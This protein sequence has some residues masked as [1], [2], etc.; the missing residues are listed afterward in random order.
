MKISEVILEKRRNAEHP[1]QQREF[2]EKYLASL[3]SLDGI[4]LH[5]TNMDKIGINP[6]SD[7]YETPRGIYA[8]SAVYNDEGEVHVDWKPGHQRNTNYVFV[9]KLKPDARI[10]NFKTYTLE[11]F[12]KDLETLGKEWNE[13]YND[14]SQKN[15]AQVIYRLA[16]G[17][18][19]NTKSKGG[20]NKRSEVFYRI[21]GYDG[22]KDPGYSIIH[23]N[24]PAQTVFFHR[25]AFDVLKQLRDYTFDQKYKN[26]KYYMNANQIEQQIAKGNWIVISRIKP[27]DKIKLSP[28]NQM[29]LLKVNTPG[30][31]RKH[32]H[33]AIIAVS[34]PTDEFYKAVVD[35]GD[36]HLITDTAPDNIKLYILSKDP[37][38]IVTMKSAPEG[39]LEV[40]TKTVGAEI[41]KALMQVRSS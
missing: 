7:W 9:L 31:G 21:L 12:K 17:R 24:E 27:G 33:D 5:Y 20:N 14:Y 32:I 30:I 4:Y 1:A 2:L 13:D 38:K 18:D 35:Q 34:N 10:L 8:Y 23:K 28:E 36:S 16:D 37:S 25:G 29:K 19:L 26:F 41:A 22:L 15:I 6:K 3:P 40:L 39:A 11:Q